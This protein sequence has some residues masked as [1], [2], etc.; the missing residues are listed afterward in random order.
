MYLDCP[1]CN[2]VWHLRPAPSFKT[3]GDWMK[4]MLPDQY[5][6]WFAGKTSA[7]MLCF[8]CSK[9]CNKEKKQ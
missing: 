5:E 1:E 6:D 2:T 3:D 8:R 7:K 4:A 9:G